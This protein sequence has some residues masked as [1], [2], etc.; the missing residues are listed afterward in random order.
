L[1]WQINF[2]GAP[3]TVIEGRALRPGDPRFDAPA[4]TFAS[5]DPPD[6]APEWRSTLGDDD[7][8][9]LIDDDV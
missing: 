7:E 2:T 6:R 5:I 8:E 4:P 3:S 1:C 9:D